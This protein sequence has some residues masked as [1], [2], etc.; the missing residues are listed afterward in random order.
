MAKKLNVLKKRNR[1][2]MKFANRAGHIILIVFSFFSLITQAAVVTN[3]VA[4]KTTNTRKAVTDIQLNI[5]LP[6]VQ[7]RYQDTASQ[8]QELVIHYTYTISGQVYDRFLLGFEYLTAGENTGNQ[9]FAIEKKFT[10]QMVFLGYTALKK[11]FLVSGQHL[12]EFMLTPELVLGQSS[13]EVTT[14]LLGGSQ[15]IKSA[16]E[17]SYGFGLIGSVRLGYLLIESDFRYQTSKNYEPD[18]LMLGSVRIGAHF[19]F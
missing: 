16:N 17:M 7:M 8:S 10:E 9:S 6:S 12:M 15:S 4:S 2:R 13:N 1:G 14:L 18:S 19:G 11:D 5:F 3:S